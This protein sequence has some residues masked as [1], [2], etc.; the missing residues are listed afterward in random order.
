MM[1]D[2]VWGAIPP[3]SPNIDR[4]TKKGFSMNTKYVE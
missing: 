3:M 2:D 1:S 4:W